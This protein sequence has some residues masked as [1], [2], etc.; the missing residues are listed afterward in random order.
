MINKNKRKKK[1]TRNDT[2]VAKPQ[3]G[4]VGQCESVMTVGDEEER[5]AGAPVFA[6]TRQG[7]STQHL[8]SS[9]KKKRQKEER[10]NDLIIPIPPI[11]KHKT[12]VTSGG[13]KDRSKRN[14]MNYHNELSTTKKM[15]D[16]HKNQKKKTDLE[17]PD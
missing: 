6:V 10:E 7:S 15:T 4:K 16:K 1:I 13:V 9:T 5:G 2:C 12:N 14:Y 17:M 8:Q 3:E 11:Q